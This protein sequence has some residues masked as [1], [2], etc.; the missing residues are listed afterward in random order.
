M[1]IRIKN[2]DLQ[3]DI[4]KGTIQHNVGDMS[5]VAR[6]TVFV[7]PVACILDHID[8]YVSERMPPQVTTASV[9]IIT[10]RVNLAA[11][12]DTFLAVKTSTS[13]SDASN[14]ILANTR[15]RITMSAN[16][17]LT[18]GTPIA[19]DISAV[20]SANLSATVCVAQYTPLKHRESR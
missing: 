20:A 19:L 5:A 13:Q 12:S 4:L 9:T 16:N 15:Y 6:H 17:S 14:A 3:S 8:V 2:L 11:D 10:V 18:Q 1:A 7:A